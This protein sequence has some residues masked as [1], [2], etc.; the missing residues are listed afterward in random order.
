LQNYIKTKTTS[1]FIT[2]ISLLTIYLYNAHR[3][4]GHLCDS[5]AFLLYMKWKNT[6][7]FNNTVWSIGNC[8]TKYR[9]LCS[10]IKT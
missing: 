7:R 6:A 1:F 3:E 8:R 2:K 5:T 4:V 9:H 10:A